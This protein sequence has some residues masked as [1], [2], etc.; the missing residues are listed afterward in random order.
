MFVAPGAN[1]Y[2]VALYVPSIKGAHAFVQ[3]YLYGSFEKTG[4]LSL[5]QFVSYSSIQSTDSFLVLNSL[6]FSFI[7]LKTYW[8][9]SSVGMGLFSR[10]NY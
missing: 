2:H 5:N 3:L 4:R 6:N 8:S 9:L 1:P 7:N 10:C